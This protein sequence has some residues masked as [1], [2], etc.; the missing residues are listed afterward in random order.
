MSQ[1]INDSILNSNF[2]GGQGGS[3][4]FELSPEEII[5]TECVEVQSDADAPARKT[6]KN[7]IVFAVAAAL[8]VLGGVATQSD[9][10]LSWLDEG[11]LSP[12][13]AFL[14]KPRPS[15]AGD[16]VGVDSAPSLAPASAPALN[17]FVAAL[18]S[19]AA[20]SGG[21]PDVAV[22]I[23]QQPAVLP[24]D[25]HGT[26]VSSNAVTDPT[27]TGQNAAGQGAATK[28]AQ[29]SDSALRP[30]TPAVVAAQPAGAALVSNGSAVA[31]APVSTSATIA[32]AAAAVPTSVAH[33]ERPADAQATAQMGDGAERT[34]NV[35]HEQATAKAATSPEVVQSTP[36]T[37]TV[38]KATPPLRRAP[39]VPEN[40]RES[41]EA[42]AEKVRSVMLVTA[43]Q[44]GLRELTSERLVVKVGSSDLQF[45]V[46]DVL[47]SGERI[48]K[49]DPIAMAVITDRS[50]IR[51]RP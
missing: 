16:R 3:L 12:E 28:V 46:S 48:E 50:V 11:A 39:A 43:A 14:E 31:I 5:D 23:Q 8:A 4:D 27:A 42:P 49:I 30:P 13:L 6:R 34:Q 36:P 7:R 24:D 2:G 10:A 17:P 26:G 38:A 47:P 35:A 9:L 18:P 19:T 33:P 25:V 44:I 20:T 32:N 15:L 41:T 45:R 1:A 21:V 51:V 40:R 29:T 37:R 22:A